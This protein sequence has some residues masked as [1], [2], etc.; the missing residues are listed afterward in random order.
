ML[1]FDADVT[2]LAEDAYQGSDIAR[3]RLAMLGILQAGRGDRVLDIGC[4]PGMLA[5][6]LSRAVGDAGSVLGIDPSPDMLAAARKRCGGRA[7]VSF[8][9]G[10]ANALPLDDAAVDRAVA[11]QVFEYLEDIPGALLE[12]RR[13][14]D[15]DGRLVIGNVHW[16][17]L[18]WHSADRRRMARLLEA[19]DSHLAEPCVPALLPRLLRDAG[20]VVERVEPVPVCDSTLRAD[21]L[22]QM[23][24]H[25]IEGFAVRNGLIE[26]EE[27]RAWSE[28]QRAL[29]REGRFFFALTQFVIA[30]RRAD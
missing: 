1:E 19:W 18:V 12:A 16:G 11:L 2:R 14:L 21:G 24:L 15:A 17:S 23:L 30:A 9:D 28:E 27:A 20:F 22:A 3:R 29:A 13:V 7:N 4:G 8:M 25:L 5:L 26:P 10:T 6:E